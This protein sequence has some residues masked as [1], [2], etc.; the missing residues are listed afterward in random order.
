M[1]EKTANQIYRVRPNPKSRGTRLSRG[2]EM[3]IDYAK[4]LEAENRRL[5]KRIEEF[6][7]NEEPPSRNA[8]VIYCGAV[9]EHFRK[10]KI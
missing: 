7:K 9:A 3:W 6:E 4:N 2:G 5:K 1:D 8:D 10:E